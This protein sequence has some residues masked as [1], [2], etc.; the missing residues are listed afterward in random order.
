MTTNSLASATS[1]SDDPDSPFEPVPDTARPALKAI[2]R[3]GDNEGDMLPPERV[4]AFNASPEGRK[5][6]SWVNDQYRTASNNRKPYER[7]WI[8]NYAFYDGKQYVEWD[9]QVNNG[10]GG[11]VNTPNNSRWTPRIVVNRIQ[12][13]IRT[14]QAKLLGQKPTATVMPDSNDDVDIFAAQAGERVWDSLYN[15][16][17]FHGKLASSIFWLSI[18]GTSF[19]KTCWDAEAWDAST[20]V[21]GDVEWIPLTPYQ[22]L[23]PDLLEPDIEKQQW[24]MDVQAKPV[25]WLE[26]VYG[27]YFPKGV[28][29]SVTRVDEIMPARAVGSQ[30]G[31][32]KP[33]SAIVMEVWIKP[34]MCPELLEGG[35]VTVV[36]N[37]IVQA[38]IHGMPYSHKEY[39]FAKFMHIPTGKFYGNSII[40]PL[41]PLQ[42]EYNRTQ[43]Q[44][45]EAKNRMAKPQV[46][47]REGSVIPD[48]IT[49]E[50][51]LYIPVKGSAEFPQSVQ[52]TELPQYVVQFNERQ[53]GDFENISGQHAPTRGDLPAGTA[54]TGFA[55]ALEQDDAFLTT[56]H[57]S[58]ERAV[59]KIA[60]QTLVL[61]SN[62]WT[63]PRLVKATGEDGGLDAMLL[64]GSQLEGS[65]D[66]RIE[67][68]SSLSTSKSARQAQVTEWMKFGWIDPNEGFEL[69]DMPML[70]QWVN[71]RKVD[72]KAAQYENIE[73]RDLVEQE[74]IDFQIEQVELK[75]QQLQQEWSQKAADIES[76]DP[77]LAGGPQIDPVTG[78]PMPP[79]PAAQAAEAEQAAN[80]L[81]MPTDPL[82]KPDPLGYMSDPSPVATPCIVPV[83][84]WDD[85]A[86]HIE[87]HNLW[88]KSPSFKFVP[89]AIRQEVEKHVRLH[90]LAL[91]GN[92][93]KEAAMM[94][95]A[96]GMDAQPTPPGGPKR[97]GMDAGTNPKETSP[98]QGATEE[99]LQPPK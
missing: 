83:N 81:S 92:I 14:E 80:I 37:T 70:N 43:S 28:K 72:K 21:Y 78:Q 61:C 41:I 34:N 20:K 35:M 33:D 54:A 56:T 29:P 88:R 75:K 93:Q 50:P 53:E 97:G 66:I 89:P 22:V 96:G 67:S 1:V 90:E 87:I 3:P 8:M 12:P 38:A 48:R 57:Q 95:P 55:Y 23:V 77:T 2:T 4:R 91:A 44:I 16:L 36:D 65:T 46:Y 30:A 59:Q 10:Q 71:R 39:P 63:V 47:F 76:S 84:S 25:K 15:R 9:A 86:V 19:M 62:Y 73:F 52:L 13:V 5:L 60:R 64:R 18:T 94:A 17:D 27:E 99:Q 45:I 24:V 32:E 40:E 51:G 11:L 69:L 31:E 26:E 7:R 58:I 74:V 98:F 68:G 82:P 79:D 49:S 85:H 42:R 6:V